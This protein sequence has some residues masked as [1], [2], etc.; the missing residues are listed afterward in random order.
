MKEYTTLR[1][2]LLG[3]GIIAIL[4]LTGMN[5]YS[6][7]ALRETTIES[8]RENRKLE[9]TEMTEK[10]RNR[11][12]VPYSGLSK[13]D[14][15]HE[16]KKFRSTG[17][18]T[19]HLMARIQ[20]AAQDPIYEG[21]YY[22]PA[23]SWACNNNGDILK[24]DR[25]SKHLVS[26]NDY[27]DLVCDGAVMARTRMKVL[28]DEYLFNNKVIF[29]THRSMTLALINLS[30]REVFGYLTM[31]IDQDHLI[32]DYLAGLLTN[33][34]GEAEQSGA[35]VWLRDW[36]RNETIA[37]SDPDKAFGE[38][39]IHYHQKFPDLFDDW[40][41]KV[42]FTDNPAIAASKASLIKNMIVLGAAFFLLLG[43]LVFMFITAQRERSLAKRQAGF[44]ANV[45]HELKTPLTVMQAAGENLADGRVIDR[46]RLKSY[47]NH[48]YN[49]AVRLK[50]MIEKLLDVAKAD[51][52]QSMIEPKP[53]R[54][55]RL[56]KS[57][58]DNHRNFIESRGFELDLDIPD[59]L[60]RIMMDPENFETVLG[61]LI[62]NAIKYSQGDKYLGISMKH[63][64]STL[65]IVVED[66][67]VGI[68]KKSVKYIFDKFYRVEDV[69]T[70]STKGHGLGLSIVKNLVELNGG[71]IDVESEEGEGSKFI[72]EFPV[73]TETVADEEQVSSTVPSSEKAP[74]E[75]VEEQ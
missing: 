33:K 9:I 2:V 13:V 63:N 36:T 19:G 22:L 49:E 62:E 71:T 1:W 72:L 53:I 15:D 27:P 67:G 24:Y 44:L 10:I 40:R 45:T 23:D 25:E 30:N 34:F 54:P 11:F 31:L 59:K 50:R 5:V 57:Y 41:L 6:L 74:Y 70:A 43:A 48:I 60:P 46:E 8:E 55:G 18:F 39:D 37:S 20:R 73:L 75:Y 68:S 38:Y 16:E 32:N 14:M 61:N 35:I 26:V 21:V 29:D 66:R 7:Y 52:N 17:H 51:A 65:R 47:G 69:M 12:L 58:L 4:G 28:I 42:S 64:D 3:A 56:L